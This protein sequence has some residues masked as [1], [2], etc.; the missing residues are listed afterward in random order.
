LFD[1]FRKIEQSPAPM[2]LTKFTWIIFACVAASLNAQTPAP[3]PVSSPDPNTR[4]LSLDEAVR[5]AL[6]HN[7]DVKILEVGPQL[8]RY[9]LKA[10]Y[11]VYDPHL[12][13]VVNHEESIK[14]G[15]IKGG[16]QTL[17]NSTHVDS[18]GILISRGPKQ[19]EFDPKFLVGYLPTGLKYAIDANIN[20]STG[21]TGGLGLDQYDG[22]I[23][24]VLRQPLLRDAWIDEPRAA[25][26]M[27]KKNVAISEY[28]LQLKLMQVVLTTQQAYYDLVA[29]VDNV[30]VQ[31]NALELAQQAVSD[32]K[33]R[34]QVGTVLP[35]TEKSAESAAAAARADLLVAKR[36]Q[37]FQENILKQILSDDYEKWHTMSIAPSEKLLAIPQ[38]YNLQASWVEG[39]THRP[40]FNQMRAEVERQ[41]IQVKLTKNQLFPTLDITGAAGRGTVDRTFTGSLGD[42]SSNKNPIWS[43]GAIVSIPFTFTENRNN[44]QAARAKMQELQLQL[45]KAHQTVIISIDDA[46]QAAQS[47]F[48]RVAARREA[49]VF[50]ESA[51]DAATKRFQNDKVTA[52]EVLQVQRDLTTARGLEIQALADYN[53]ALSQLY[54]NEGTILR[55]AGLEVKK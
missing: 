4:V 6:E 14:E 43:I 20:H 38:T 55:R 44:H 5:L 26:A 39:L 10:S 12:N 33:K 49:R 9:Q 37:D 19:D 32:T 36:Q 15:K 23:G 13:F 41:G 50:A 27:N 22:D 54:Y 47:T 18:F 35:L 29:A 52:Y 1:E 16:I 24:I 11:G 31:Q 28:A 21:V 48:Q 45:Q 25:I 2:Q 8:A 40:D 30:R 34:V 51:L 7:L 42:I 46:M 3:A 53:K 17:P